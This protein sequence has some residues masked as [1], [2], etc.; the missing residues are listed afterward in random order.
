MSAK[1][2]EEQ[3]RLEEEK[4]TIR[5]VDPWWTKMKSYVVDKKNFATWEELA[6]DMPC[7]NSVW[8]S[9]LNETKPAHCLL[10]AEEEKFSMVLSN[11]LF[12]SEGIQFKKDFI[13]DSP[14]ICSQPAP[15]INVT[16]FSIKFY[17]MPVGFSPWF[18]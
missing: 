3:E 5:E 11:F 7:L 9:Q 2:M 13:F 17:I 14:L 8:S 1:E 10:P 4:K 16:K 12:S 6:Y 18:W 15:R